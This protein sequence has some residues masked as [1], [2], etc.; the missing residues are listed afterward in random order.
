MKER[1]FERMTLAELEALEERTGQRHELWQGQPVAMTGGTAA[2]NLVALGLYRAV[3]PQLK[4]DC[5]AF[6]ADVKL[7]LDEADGGDT[8]YPDM[9][10]VCNP[11]TG[12]RQTRP[13]L[14]AEVLSDSSVRRDRVDKLRAYSALDSLQAY[15]I[16]SQQ[17]VEVDVYLRTTQWQRERYQG[18]ASTIELA[19]LEM[20]LALGDIYADVLA[21]LGY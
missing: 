10:V 13:I 12:N 7:R 15:L 3:Y 14:V 18:L 21:D 8:T 1:A 20:R 2:H 6:V 5:R 11:L 9:M 4:P 19:A 17:D 16:L